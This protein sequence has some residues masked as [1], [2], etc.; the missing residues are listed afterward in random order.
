[1]LFVRINLQVWRPE[2]ARVVGVRQHPSPAVARLVRRGGKSLAPDDLRC[3][4]DRLSMLAP[5][6]LI[7]WMHDH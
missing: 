1:L 7:G 2:F 3:Y 6:D 5:A 4:Q